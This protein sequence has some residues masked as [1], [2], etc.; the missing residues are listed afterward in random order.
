MM[1][2]VVLRPWPGVLFFISFLFFFSFFP[3]SFVLCGGSEVVHI[4]TS[5]YE[6]YGPPN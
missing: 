4:C 2:S 5:S 6:A 3:F 1:R